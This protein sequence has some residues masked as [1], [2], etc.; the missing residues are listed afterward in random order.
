MRTSVL[1]MTLLLLLAGHVEV[2]DG[3]KNGKFNSSSGCGCHSGGAPSVTASL[4]GLP[5]AYVASTTYSLSIG[6]SSSPSTGGF[7]LAVNAGILS[8]PGSD[9][10]VSSNGLQATHSGPNSHSWTVDWTSP[11]SGSG[12][13]Q[14]NLATVSGD[15]QSNTGGDGTGTLSTSIGEDVPSNTAPSATDLTL[16]PS[17]PT[18]SDDLMASY[19][20]VDAEGD[21]ESGTSFA[22]HLNDTLVPSQT[23]SILP[24]S[25]TSKTQ[26]WKVVVTPSDGANTGSAVESA[27]VTISNSP[28][29]AS[30]V[31][32]NELEPSSSTNL[33]FTYHGEDPDGDDYTTE[34]RWHLNGQAVPELNNATVLPS[35]ATRSGDIWEVQVRLSD[36]ENASPWTASNNVTIASGNAAP[37]ITQVNIASTGTVLTTDNLLL[38]WTSEDGDG[39]EITAHE[40]IWVANG[41]TISASEGMNPLVS[42][43][44][45]KGES[46]QGLV[47]V[48]DGTSWSVWA[49]SSSVIIENTAP[50]ILTAELNSSTFT[51]KHA[52]HLQ[53]STVDVDNDSVEL[54][55]VVWT[56]NG[57]EQTA[58]HD[59]MS[60]DPT[61]LTKGDTWSAMMTLSDGTSES[62]STSS[63]ITI[64]NALP[65][66]DIIW[67]ENITSIEDL[68]PEIRTAD[69]DNDAVEFST[70]WYKNGFRDASLDNASQVPATKLAPGQTWTLIVQAS[71]EEATAALVESTH[72]I[73][74]M[75]PVASIVVASSQTWAGERVS[76]SAESSSDLDGDSLTYTWSWNEGTASGSMLVLIPLN[77][78][79]VTLTVT[80]DSGTT[81]STNITLQPTIGPKVNALE[82]TARNDG[83]IDLSWSWN[84]DDVSYNILRN[85][86]LIASVNETSYRDSPPM[87]GVNHY[88]I[89]PYDDERTYL[90][91]VNEANVDV[92]M[93]EV[94]TPEASAAAGYGI[95]A[96]LLLVSIFMFNRTMRGGRAQ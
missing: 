26:S 59:E 86:E 7:N 92:L 62:S 60:I 12:S 65:E 90:A 34:V 30:N 85:G 41:Q 45:A 82:L 74:N 84:G 55:E 39:D 10:Q 66:V 88:M 75:P 8:N 18:T 13:I 79:T 76:L 93:P 15:G 9:A 17:V 40:V 91:A 35:L 23:N 49:T 56:K 73:A 69:A 68:T 44:T 48:S 77:E 20:F 43:M 11:S 27:S 54:T 16:Q 67:S 33:T 19:T 37:I 80:D 38:N 42:T 1:V 72:L 29:A 51:V 21:G 22:W 70:S 31:Q 78:M 50:S 71:D 47:R 83:G 3:K 6:M 2:V 89:Q 4:T 53:Y 5:N 14:F 81:H 64:L 61:L 94:E 58:L 95:G 32:L 24:S 87:S 96:A 46:W 36:G 25:A 63:T 28:P 52:L 57:V